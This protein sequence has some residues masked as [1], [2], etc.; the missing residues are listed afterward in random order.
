MVNRSYCRGGAGTR[1][2]CG[3]VA[4]P[5]KRGH[6]LR[7]VHCCSAALL[8]LLLLLCVLLAVGEFCASPLA[9]S[10]PRPS[11]LPLPPPN[12]RAG[13]GGGGQVAKDALGND[14]KSNAWLATHQKGDHSLVQGL[15]VSVSLAARGS[16]SSTRSIG[17][18]SFPDSKIDLRGKHRIRQPGQ[19]ARAWRAMARGQR[20]P[21]PY[22]A[23]SPAER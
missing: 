22:S 18:R 17:P 9:L 21:R 5:R 23:F 8:Q 6:A 16:S 19:R 7:A 15:K 20:G 4:R 14:V 12:R 10:S 13:G 3:G 11:P 2:R 1:R